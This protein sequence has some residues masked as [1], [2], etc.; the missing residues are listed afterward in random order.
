[1]LV[2]AAFGVV[3]AVGAV[4]SAAKGRSPLHRRAFLV[5][6]VASLVVSI[7]VSLSALQWISQTWFFALSIPALALL[8]WFSILWKRAQRTGGP[9][10]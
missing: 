6:A 3:L 1:M 5:L 2:G 8:L 4:L 9:Q 7:K 10:A